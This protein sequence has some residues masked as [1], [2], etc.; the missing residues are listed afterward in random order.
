MICCDV[1]VLQQPQLSTRSAGYA[2]NLDAHRRRAARE[3]ERGEACRI[4][5]GRAGTA[6]CSA[7]L[8]CQGAP[9]HSS[10]SVSVRPE[11]WLRQ[12][13][14]ERVELGQQAKE[15]PQAPGSASLSPSASIE[16]IPELLSL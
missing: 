14:E 8:S 3:E 12:R 16:R 9:S 11:Q 10:C 7:D 15:R 4:G 6:S 5:E 1:L 13:R 2:T